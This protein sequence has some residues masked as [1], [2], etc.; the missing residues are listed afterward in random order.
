VNMKHITWLLL[1]AGAVIYYSETSKGTFL[2]SWESSLPGS[3]S[4]G[5]GLGE[6]LGIAGVGM[7][8]YN[9]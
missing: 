2:F 6:Y 4:L 9:R 3:T 5:L 7:L 8:L 1:I